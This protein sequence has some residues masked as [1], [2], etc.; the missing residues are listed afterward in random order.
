MAPIM[1]EL[2]GATR[3]RFVTGAA[4]GAA[5]VALPAWG[6]DLTARPG[7][8]D[9]TIA[10]L[11]V[12]FTGKRA[13]ATAINGTI[14]GP[15]LRF[16]QGE[17]AT[18]RVTNRLE[19]MTSIHW[20]GLLLPPDMDGVPGISFPGIAPGETFTHRFPIKQ[21]GTYWY[22][23][24][25]LHEQTGVYGSIVIEGVDEDL[26]KIDRD[27]VV[28]LSE[29]SDENPLS[30]F[31]KLKKL[32]GY[33]NFGQPNLGD[34]M[35]DVQK[36][37][38]SGAMSRRSMFYRA[39]MDPTDLSDIS[40]YTFTYLMNGTPPGGNWTGL[41]YRSERVR[42]RFVGAG[43]ATYFDVRIPGLKLTVIATDGQ[44]VYPVLVDEF[45]I[46]PGETYDVLV[47]LPDDAA[48]TIFAQAMD[49]SGYARG[50]LGGPE[51]KPA[52]MPSMDPR[53][54]LTQQDMMG[55]MAMAGMPGMPPGAGDAVM[56]R[57]A[58]TEYGPSVDMRVDSPRV[59]L[60]DPGIGLRDNGRRVLTYA[61]L[62]SKGVIY[63]PRPAG[64]EIEL[65][66]TGNM[67]Q[68]IWSIDGI[69]YSESPPVA[70]K[71]GEQ[72]RMVLVNDTMM[73]HPM[74]LHGMWMDLEGPDGGFQVR[75]HTVNVQPAQRVSIG[76]TADAPGRWAF[77]CHI[78]YHMAAGMFR[79][80]VVA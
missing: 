72:L 80:V 21:S 4:A 30:I 71:T 77:H 3:R 66:L 78:L 13:M 64:R 18:L 7:E 36:T 28:M 20:H 39:R 24:H 76:I 59:N 69:R 67:D 57:H 32:G 79:E 1:D 6:Q 51:A 33:Y 54:W 23:A 68:Y 34:F 31:M 35:A 45:R 75:K 61:D 42:L 2:R 14:P 8:Y 49:R 10:P 41:A 22:H 63:D 52:A 40:G 44:P 73:T 11:S 29:W 16:R 56:A 5:S 43:A 38:F 48:Y 53:V 46:G 25:T 15:A 65:H 58:R 27:Y 26:P 70:F 60:D 19:E 74:H 12:N 47:E 62:K 50:T 37:S 55:S 9:L 17:M